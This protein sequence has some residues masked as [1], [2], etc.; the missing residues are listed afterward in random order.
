MVSQPDLR[1]HQQ[2]MNFQFSGVIPRVS[3][4]IT[5]GE[6]PPALDVVQQSSQAVGCLISRGLN[7]LVIEQMHKH[8][9]RGIVTILGI[10]AVE[11]N[12]F[13]RR[14]SNQRE[15]PFELRRLNRMETPTML[16][17][18]IGP[19]I[20]A[21]GAFEVLQVSNGSRQITSSFPE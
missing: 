16:Q 17:V 3:S 5:D 4:V 19:F 21:A 15:K 9:S 20:G 7:E 8:A 14:N 1:T 6:L 13:R 11:R 10:V 18:R 2:E 12:K